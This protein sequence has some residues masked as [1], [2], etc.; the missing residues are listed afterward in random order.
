MCH[1][2]YYLTS[3]SRNSLNEWQKKG[4]K[5]RWLYVSQSLSSRKGDKLLIN[6]NECSGK[7][8]YLYWFSF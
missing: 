5:L 3:L 6:T 4:W 8:R 2:P 7:Q 1:I